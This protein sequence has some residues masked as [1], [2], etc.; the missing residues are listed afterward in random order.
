MKSLKT[1]LYGAMGSILFAGAASANGYK[2]PAVEWEHLWV[3]VMVDITV[4]GV[5]FAIAAIYMLIRFRATS[6]D[7]VGTAKP[8]SAVGSIVWALVPASIFMADDFF[9]AAKGWSAWNTYRTVPEGVTEIQVTGNMWYWDFEYPDGTES[10]TN[11]YD[12]EDKR[13]CGDGLVLPV[14]QPVV[15]RMTSNDV[16]HSFSLVKYRVKEDVMPGRSTHIWFNPTE[17]TDTLVTCV[18]F[19]GDNHSRMYGKVTILSQ[20]DYDAWLDKEDK[21]FVA[22]PMYNSYDE[23]L[24]AQPAKQG[25]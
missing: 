6:P 23:Y 2:N 12:D 4:I 11:C 21:E 19:C 14:G 24:K 7:Q 3:E 16:I 5:L 25:S 10:S 13:I 8:L 9:L 20:E 18:E 1:A 22:P 17:V 15:L